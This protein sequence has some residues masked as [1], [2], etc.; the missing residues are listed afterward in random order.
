MASSGDPRSSSVTA[1]DDS[2]EAAMVEAL[3]QVRAQQFP[4][5]AAHVSPAEPKPEPEPE[6]EREPE[7]EPELE[8][9]P[10]PEQQRVQ[11]A[12]QELGPAGALQSALKDEVEPAE[13]FL[14][15]ELT[16]APEFPFDVTFSE[17]GQLGLSLVRARTGWTVV[18]RA[19]PGT[20]AAQ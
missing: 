17:H 9:E 7:P 3:L 2:L 20:Q 10:E 8:L 13:G 5:A 18:S 16:C 1:V 11:F 6:L 15:P 12:A 14:V 4:T 19:I